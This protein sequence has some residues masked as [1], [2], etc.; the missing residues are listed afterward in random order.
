MKV[1]HSY[2]W[3]TWRFEDLERGYWNNVHNQR[4]FLEYLSNHLGI[5]DWKDWYKVGSFL[6]IF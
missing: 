2:P 3:Q 1:Y 5:Q 4:Q 6:R